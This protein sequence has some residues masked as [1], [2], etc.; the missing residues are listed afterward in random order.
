M[1]AAEAKC[2]KMPVSGS[3]K[4]RWHRGIW[5]LGPSR[6][7][8]EPQSTSFEMPLKYMQD[9]LSIPTVRLKEKADL[10]VK[11]IWHDFQLN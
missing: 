3:G 2:R 5:G 6:E 1:Q 4:E 11:I 8:H 7:Q 10:S 9:G